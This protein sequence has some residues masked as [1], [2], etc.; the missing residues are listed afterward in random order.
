MRIEIRHSDRSARHD[1]IVEQRLRGELEMDCYLA[2]N[3]D[4]F[5]RLA[6]RYAQESLRVPDELAQAS[7][8]EFL[9]LHNG[10]FLVNMSDRGIELDMTPQAVWRVDAD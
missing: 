6:S 4:V 3:T 8:G 5:V 1:W 10:I 7:V 2:A 9:N